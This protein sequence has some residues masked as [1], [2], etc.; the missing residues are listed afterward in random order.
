MCGIIGAGNF[1]RK[2]KETCNQWIINQYENQFD[3]GT[4]GF[5]V[6]FINHD[7]S[8]KIER[9]CEP[10]KLMFDLHLNQAPFI[11]MHH[12][13]PTSSGNRIS[14][15]HPIQVNHGSLEKKYLVIHNGVVTNDD[16]LKKQHEEELGFQYTTDEIAPSAYTKNN[17]REFNDS[18]TIA[19]EFARFIEKQTK[20]IGAQGSHALIALEI[21]K[22]TDKVTNIHF[23]R[24]R[25]PI[26]LS[27]NRDKIRLSSE[28]EGDLIKENTL[29]SFDIKTKKLSKRKCP[30]AQYVAPQTQWQPVQTGFT[31]PIQGIIPTAPSNRITITNPTTD[32]VEYPGTNFTKD[33]EDE[34]DWIN[35]FLTDKIYDNEEQKQK[36]IRA[37]EEFDAE[38]ENTI[39][40]IL[41]LA[42]DPETISQIRARDFVD[43]VEHG[44]TTLV[45]T[46]R[47]IAEERSTERNK[48]LPMYS[49]NSAGMYDLD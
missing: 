32:N 14:Q 5:G 8:Y 33:V 47:E 22:K 12:R 29:Y 16:E 34:E 17:I 49:A 31:T 4:K 7:G 19:I 24:N 44:I 39:E 30:F 46:L 10:A 23:S 40:E 11:I 27:F 43:G 26:H 42:E 20:T 37:L 25:N 35:S 48:D 36:I 15:T 45:N 3:R 41:Q 6:V 28:G 9:A 13:F 21:D 1:N 18:E 2:E 38:Y